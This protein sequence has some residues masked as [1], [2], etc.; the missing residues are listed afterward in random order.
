MFNALTSVQLLGAIGETIR[1]TTALDTL[2][3]YQRSQLASAYSVVRLLA[4]EEAA[5][6]ALVAWTRGALTEA[7][8]GDGRAAAR[9]ADEAV[10]AAGDGRA[11]GTAVSRLLA[12][13]PLED[14]ARARVRSVLREMTDR[15]VLALGT[16]AT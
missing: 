1:A 3:E 15:E 9:T 12:D 16:P 11:I 6:A 4:S 2:P 10:R 14:A 5:A 7:L 13:L 8:A